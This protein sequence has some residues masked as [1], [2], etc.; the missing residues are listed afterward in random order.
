MKEEGRKIYITLK[1]KKAGREKAD[2]EEKSK[3]S[4]SIKVEINNFTFKVN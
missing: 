3:I 4:C 1:Q 2:Q